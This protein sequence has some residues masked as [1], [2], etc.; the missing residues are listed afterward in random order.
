[1]AHYALL[2]EN[3]IV[4]QVITGLDETQLIQKLDPETWYGQFHNQ[5]CKRTS[6]NTNSG[7]HSTGGTP[8]RKN[9]AGIGY[10]YDSERDAFIPPSPYASWLLNEQTCNWEAPIP[11]PQDGLY[12]N[13]NEDLVV[14]V[15]SEED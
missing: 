1:M 4:T 9:F 7:I 10:T 13:W 6:Y 11:Y 3:N 15:L 8:F 12:Y 14:W 5:V 2:D